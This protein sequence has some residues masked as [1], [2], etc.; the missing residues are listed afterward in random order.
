MKEINP[1]AIVKEAVDLKTLAEIANSEHAEGEKKGK[2]AIEHYVKSGNALLAIKASIG[3][4]G[5]GT[6]EAKNLKFNGRTAQR[7]RCLARKAKTT[8][9][10]DLPEAWNIILGHRDEQIEREEAQQPASPSTVCPNCNRKNGGKPLQGCPACAELR[11]NKPK[12]A[13]VA[14]EEPMTSPILPKPQPPLIVV[15]DH[16]DLSGMPMS[17]Y[18]PEEPVRNVKAENDHS[19]P[20]VPN[21]TIAPSSAAKATRKPK[22]PVEATKVLPPLTPEEQFAEEVAFARSDAALREAHAKALLEQSLDEL[23]GIA[24]HEPHLANHSL[25]AAI[26]EFLSTSK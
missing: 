26:R 22:K 18:N 4:G 25:I 7:Y 12:S 21:R 20:Q 2:E 24:K 1:P 3:H 14:K 15:P 16:T 17:H 19:L 6:W 23:D 11:K 10:S 5:L 9:A 13:P 8:P